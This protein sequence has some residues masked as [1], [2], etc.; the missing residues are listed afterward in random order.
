[1]IKSILDNSNNLKPKCKNLLN[2][3]VNFTNVP[4]KKPKF[5]VSIIK[6]IVYICMIP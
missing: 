2:H 3:I 5:I 1:M 6:S 4:R